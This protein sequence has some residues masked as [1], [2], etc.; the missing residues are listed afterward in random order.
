[1]RIPKTSTISLALTS[2]SKLTDDI[3]QT[4]TQKAQAR[5]QLE[6]LLVRQKEDHEL[7]LLADLDPGEHVA[8][9]LELTLQNEHRRS[10]PY[11]MVW[12]VNSGVYLPKS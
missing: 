5:K 1:M 3:S 9:K 12:T 6:S 10:H 4:H 2:T 7:S 11:K 8:G